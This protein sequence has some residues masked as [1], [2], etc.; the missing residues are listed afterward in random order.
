MST[1]LIEKDPVHCWYRSG[2]IFE[3][4]FQYGL[5]QA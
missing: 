4:I 5:L 1:Y 2:V 3:S